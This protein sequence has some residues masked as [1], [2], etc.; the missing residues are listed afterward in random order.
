MSRPRKFL[1]WVI[2]AGLLYF[3][4]G[5]HFIF[6][7]NRIKLLKKSR[8]TLDYT[9]FST[10]GKTNE[11]ILSIDP[12]RKD[13]IGELLVQTGKMSREELEQIESSAE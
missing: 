3:I 5:H 7:N 2:V 8:L 1:L 13:G 6:I 4:L 11:Y 10:E 12:L 9:I